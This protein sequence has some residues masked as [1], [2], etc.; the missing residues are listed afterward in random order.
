MRTGSIDSQPPLGPGEE[1]RRPCRGRDR[2]AVLA[3]V[4]ELESAPA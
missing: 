2:S 3:F 1:Q 4:G